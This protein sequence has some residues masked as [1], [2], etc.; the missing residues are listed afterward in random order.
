MRKMGTI[1]SF[2]VGRGDVVITFVRIQDRF[3]YYATRENE[4]TE[5][6]ITLTDDPNDVE[7]QRKTVEIL[8]R[9]ALAY[10]ASDNKDRV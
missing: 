1:D 6:W 3:G 4:R 9:K 8:E 5:D 10:F 7:L 2:T